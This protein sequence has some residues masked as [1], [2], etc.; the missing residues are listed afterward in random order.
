MGHVLWYFS[1]QRGRS[2]CVFRI[3]G[4][5]NQKSRNCVELLFIRLS[6]SKSRRKKEYVQ[7]SCCSFERW[8]SSLLPFLRCRLVNCTYTIIAFSLIS[9]EDL[10]S[11][12]ERQKTWGNE[13]PC[14]MQIAVW[15]HCFMVSSFL[16]DRIH[17]QFFASAFELAVSRDEIFKMKM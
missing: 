7:N 13:A 3:C 2:S 8:K 14:I 9:K 5:F 15:F 12:P 1:R 16:N 6:E 17:W 4:K 10:C 11:Y